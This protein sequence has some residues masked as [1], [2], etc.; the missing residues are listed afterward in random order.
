[1]LSNRETLLVI[2][3]FSVAYDKMSHKDKMKALNDICDE[4]GISRDL[5]KDYSEEVSYTL[6]RIL[7]NIKN[8]GGI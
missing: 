8:K 7:F 2:L 4:L 3:A 5:I 1:M 6:S